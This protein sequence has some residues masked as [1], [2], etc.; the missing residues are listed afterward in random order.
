M[1]NILDSS[2]ELG[3]SRINEISEKLIG[4]EVLYVLASKPCGNSELASRLMTTFGFEVDSKTLEDVIE[5]LESLHLVGGSS[6]YSGNKPLDTHDLFSVTSLGMT[7][8][9]EWIESL[10]EIT[11]TMQFGLHQR[12]ATP[13]Q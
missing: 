13:Q 4:I 8:L 5:E 9:R 1:E 2:S 3:F 7:K 10:S 6:N 12:L 11:L